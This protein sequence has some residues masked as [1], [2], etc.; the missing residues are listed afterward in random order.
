[1][2]DESDGRQSGKKV[3]IFSV[4]PERESD[5][6]VLLQRFLIKFWDGDVLCRRYVRAFWLLEEFGSA[7]TLFLYVTSKDFLMY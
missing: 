3:G 2:K 6:K 5:I 1:M 4:P 7:V